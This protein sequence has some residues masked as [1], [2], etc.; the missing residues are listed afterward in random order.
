MLPIDQNSTWVEINLLAIA[1]NVTCFL[2]KTKGEVMAVV[3]A[4]G[5]GHGAVPVARTALHA[6]ASWCAVARIDEALDLR[7]AGITAPV[8]L[9]GHTPTGR[10]KD[11][12]QNQVSLTI[13]QASQV[14]LASTVAKELGLTA[15]LHLKVDTGMS[16]LGVQPQEALALAERLAKTPRVFFEGLFTHFAK[17]DEADPRTTKLQESLFLETL[18]LLEQKGLRP[19]IVHAANSAASLAFPST[20]FN[21]VR[22]GVA[23]YGLSPAN[24]PILLTGLVPALAWKT[25][26]S[27]VKTL[28][29]GRGVSYGHRY[30]TR[31]Y[32]R[33]A[34]VPVGYGDG[35]RR[36]DGNQLL[37]QGQRVPVVG[38][39]CMDQ[40]MLQLDDVPAANEGDEVV[41]IGLQGNMNISAEEVAK[42]WGT[43]NYEVVCAIS[44]RVPRIYLQSPE[45]ADNVPAMAT[46]RK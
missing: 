29:P 16:R 37:V 12:I 17:A 7:K 8:L 46:R 5:Y 14:E 13:W 27:Q 44:P 24:D 34:T 38:R 19:P 9:L 11:A 33:I 36:T 4:N 32:E 25:T 6:G 45:S 28:P 41:I 20:Y 10:F 3:K 40:C 2:N 30:I 26:I 15:R 18:D 43:I 35:L 23:M 31:K 21:L 1:S 39:I 22:L 42:I